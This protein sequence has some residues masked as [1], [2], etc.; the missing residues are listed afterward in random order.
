VDR[1][2]KAPP[3]ARPKRAAE[4]V[5]AAIID[6]R[7]SGDCLHITIDPSTGR[8]TY[9]TVPAH[10]PFETVSRVGVQ[11]RDHDAQ[12]VREHRDPLREAEDA[13]LYHDLSM[14]GILSGRT[15]REP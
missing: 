14:L 2:W 3:V 13:T 4:S 6:S 10:S 12:D 15:D 11:Q 9:E 5:A 1:E 7:A 8:E